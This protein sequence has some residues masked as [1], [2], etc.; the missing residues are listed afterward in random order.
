MKFAYT[1]LY[2][3]SVARSL[4]FYEA[5]FDLR[6]RHESEDYGEMETG[7][8]VLA[9]FAIQQARKNF[10]I[11]VG[12]VNPAGPPPPVEIAF[13]TDDVEAAYTHAV[14]SGALAVSPPHQ[15]P[16]GQTVAYVRDQDG[17]LIEICTPIG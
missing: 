1:I 5:A 16:W 6:R 4:E 9:F 7:G 13:A 14:Q 15:M 10:T 8:T 17:F 2:V 3:S 11:E 12:D